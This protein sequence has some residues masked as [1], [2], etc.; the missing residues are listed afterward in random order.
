[1]GNDFTTRLGRSVR[2]DHTSETCFLTP[3]GDSALNITIKHKYPE[4]LKALA[5]N[6]FGINH[7][8]SG[9][10]YPIH[11]AVTEGSLDALK[12]L[13][14]H[15]ANVNVQN[16]SGLTPLHLA[17][18]REQSQIAESLL[19]HGADPNGGIKEGS[20]NALLTPL[21][22]AADNSDYSNVKQLLDSG[23]NPDM[24]DSFGYTMLIR[25][26]AVRE[27]YHE[28]ASLLVEH[29][30][31]F[32]LKDGHDHSALAWAIYTDQCDL[33]QQIILKMKSSNLPL[34]TGESI[35]PILLAIHKNC[36]KC[37]RNLTNNYGYKALHCEAPC[38]PLEFAMLHPCWKV[39][40]IP[41]FGKG[42][43]K[44]INVVITNLDRI[45]F[46]RIILDEFDIELKESFVHFCVNEALRMGK[47]GHQIISLCLNS[48]GAYGSVKDFN[49]RL[50]QEILFEAIGRKHDR[51][52]IMKVYCTGF[53]PNT[54]NILNIHHYNVR[55][56]KSQ[57]LV[58][59]LNRMKRTPRTLKNLSVVV[60]R[61]R[62]ENNLV[63]RA[64]ALQLPS[65]IYLMLTIGFNDGGS[66]HDGE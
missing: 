65:Y 30:H 3:S 22:L 29:C 51:D 11:V 15:G 43:E 46:A 42:V 44:R 31:E 60:V 10:D 13:I 50:K 24:K 32:C 52:L 26:A 37:F 9:G 45:A 6:N 33:A 62:L 7:A 23:A 58:E 16:A 35:A 4:I 55:K 27:R 41:S 64:K 63:Y 54:G 56:N 57:D 34:P 38:P 18:L 66:F 36:W 25:A 12:L 39:D 20:Y 5:E 8:G 61:G 48:F 40:M 49:L 53:E 17:C 2:A 19:S 47:V 59:E 21:R 1:M 14:Q 28:I